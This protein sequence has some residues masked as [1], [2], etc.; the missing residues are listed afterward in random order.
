MSVGY[1]LTCAMCLAPVICCMQN[2]SHLQ[3]CMQAWCMSL[4]K[5]DKLWSDPR[6]V[7][8]LASRRMLGGMNT[9]RSSAETKHPVKAGGAQLQLRKS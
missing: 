2:D 4:W 7:Q 6:T 9:D 3:L 5:A 1:E 8:C